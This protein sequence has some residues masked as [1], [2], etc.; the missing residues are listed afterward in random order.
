MSEAPERKDLPLP[1]DLKALLL[2]G[3][4]ALMAFYALYL[5]REIVVPIIIA[6]LL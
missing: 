5:T 2:L 3:I 1:N 4:F 6:F